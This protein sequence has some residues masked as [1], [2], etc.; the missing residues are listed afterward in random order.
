VRSGFSELVE[1][2]RYRRKTEH[3][4][5]EPVSLTKFGLAMMERGFQKKANNG[6]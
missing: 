1:T 6:I 2:Q 5:E 3:S 4:G